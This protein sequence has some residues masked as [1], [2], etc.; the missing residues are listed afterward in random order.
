M[1]TLNDG[2]TAFY[3]DLSNQGL[4]NETLVLQF[5]EFGRRVARTAAM[6]PTTARP[7]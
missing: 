1:T 6:A 7:A 4:L 5:S 3:Q 2:L